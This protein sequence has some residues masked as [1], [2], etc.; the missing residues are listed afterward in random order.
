MKL[1]DYFQKL[2]EQGGIKNEEFDKFLE[3]VPDGEMPD[4]V[5][6]VLDSTFLTVTRAKSHNDVRGKI[7]A[8]LLDPID[9]DIKQIMK[10]MPAEKVIDIER[11]DS[12]YKK[13]GIIRDALPDVI[14]KAAK[15]PNDEEAKKKIQELQEANQGMVKKISE[16]NES[17]KTELQ[18]FKDEGEKTLKNYRLDSVLESKANSYTFA[19]VFKGARPALTKAALSE[20]KVKNR[21]DLIEKDGE[22]SISVL[23]EHG[24]PRFENGGNTP[25]TIDSLLDG[26]FKD[27]LKASNAE[28]QQQSQQQQPPKTFKVDNGGGNV[29]RRGANVSV[30]V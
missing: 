17:H 9:L 18:K 10:L 24:A 19:D 2:K 11:Q 3:T 15:A 28:Q 21:L 25:V 6:P 8:E 16:I 5:F 23:D 13:L 14:S 29:P 27:Y 30:Q 20:I 22:L 1:K 7:M 26:A 4:T 12:T